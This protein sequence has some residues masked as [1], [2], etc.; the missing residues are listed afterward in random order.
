MH[1]NAEHYLRP[2]VNA[3]TISLMLAILSIFVYPINKDF[4]IEV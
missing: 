2:L 3:L 1:K 4:I